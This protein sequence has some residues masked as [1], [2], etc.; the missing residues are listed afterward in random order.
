MSEQGPEE[1][2]FL[3]L[4]G[5]EF[6]VFFKASTS[7]AQDAYVLGHLRASGAIQ[8]LADLNVPAERVADEMLTRI[9]VGGETFH[10][11][12]GCLTEKDKKWSRKEADRNAAAFAELTDA[13]DR[14]TIQGAMIGLARGFFA[15][16]KVFRAGEPPATVS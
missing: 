10:V 9:M 7:A 1:E 11:L 12:A 4:D 8:V 2:K 16:G 13:T 14:A 15:T 6:S 3:K 5:R